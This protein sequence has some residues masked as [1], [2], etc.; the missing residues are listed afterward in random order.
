M[1]FTVD[2]FF[3]V[4]ARYN[5]GVWPSQVVLNVLAVLAV[6]LVFRGGPS[7]GRW[8]AAI[9]TLLWGWMAITY[10]FAYF[11]SINPA[12]WAF[13]GVFLLGA[14]WLAWIGVVRGQLRFE[15]HGGLRGWAGGVLVLFSLII[16]PALGRML[17]HL[18]PAVPTFGLPC[19]TTI[20]TIGMLMF[21][22]LPVPRSVFIVPVLW[23]VVG[24]AAAFAL[25]VYQDLCLL[26]AG[27]VALVAVIRRP[28]LTAI[29]HPHRKVARLRKRLND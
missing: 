14:L 4:L 9:L 1:P 7:Q 17:G 28:P 26:V 2:Q 29:S 18:Y 5:T 15:V 19:P 11:T 8:I 24:S 23:A 3:D 22:Q 13:G 25:G 10:H 16:Y 27:V 6:A 21:A 20:F 12:D